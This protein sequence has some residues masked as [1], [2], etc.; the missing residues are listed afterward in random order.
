[1]GFDGREIERT[2]AEVTYPIFINEA[3]YYPSKLA[4]TLCRKT[5]KKI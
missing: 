2:S 5:I 4:F 1:M 3:A